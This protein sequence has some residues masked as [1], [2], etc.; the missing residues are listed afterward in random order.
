MGYP[1]IKVSSVSGSAA[2]NASGAGPTT[3]LTGTSNATSNGATPSVIT[4]GGSPDLSGV[5]TDGTH[6]IYLDTSAGRKFSKITAV[7]NSAKTVTIEDTITGANC[8]NRSWA[9]GGMLST[10]WGTGYVRLVDDGSSSGDAKAGWIIEFQSAHAETQT[11]TEIRVGGN[12]TDG[13]LIVRGA[14]GAATRPVI[15]TSYTFGLMV[16]GQCIVS[17]FDVKMTTSANTYVVRDFVGR[18]EFRRLKVYSTGATKA[19]RGI[20][21][22]GAS[23]VYSC[24]IYDCLHGVYSETNND[25]EVINCYIH[26][27]ATA[28]VYSN[29]TVPARIVGNVIVDCGI[30][31][32]VP[33]GGARYPVVTHNILDT[34]TTGYRNASAIGASGT[35]LCASNI[36]ANC[37]TG[38]LLSNAAMTANYFAYN[39][40]TAFKSNCFWNNTTHFT[41][42]ATSTAVTAMEGGFTPSAEPFTT[43][44]KAAR[45]TAGD[46]SQT[47]ETKAVGFPAE[48][49]GLQAVSRSYLDVGLQRQEPSG[50]SMVVQGRRQSSLIRR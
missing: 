14:S 46:W 28:G 49:V 27:C 1:T 47:T 2:P 40:Y 11:T 38:L 34:C 25:D 41:L 44:T 29:V 12:T 8:T 31:I 30:G 21:L 35:G 15:T 22:N 7:D 6:C 9:I 16:R 33:S 10:L 50:G 36:F 5:A 24:E 32:D 42:N 4:L 43:A 18:V 19:T 45:K 23:R 26:D 37:T 3:A 17:D 48:V 39:F 20:N 13:P